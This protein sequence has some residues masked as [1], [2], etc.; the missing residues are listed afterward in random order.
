M[1]SPSCTNNILSELLFWIEDFSIYVILAIDKKNNTQAL[2][3]PSTNSHLDVFMRIKHFFFAK[4][5]L[6]LE[7]LVL[8]F[9]PSNTSKCLWVHGHICNLQGRSEAD[10]PTINVKIVQCAW[11]LKVKVYYT[12]HCKTGLH[13]GSTY[14]ESFE[15]QLPGLLGYYLQKPKSTQV[16]HIGPS[17][18][19]MQV[20]VSCPRFNIMPLWGSSYLWVHLGSQCTC[21]WH[22]HK[23]RKKSKLCALL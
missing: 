14:L 10:T 15:C 8:G 7:A 16:F 3:A 13:M 12:L 1:S 2:D 11:G 21:V 4:K 22:Q 9:L 20:I 18:Y 5:L 6:L 19:Y 17:V 23:E